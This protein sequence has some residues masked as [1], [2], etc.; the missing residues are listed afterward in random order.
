VP[1]Q[2]QLKR[3]SQRKKKADMDEPCDT[4]AIHV[5]HDARAHHSNHNPKRV[6]KYIKVCVCR[7]SF[8]WRT[9]THIL[10]TSTSNAAQ[11][12][13]IWREKHLSPYLNACKLQR[14]RHTL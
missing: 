14:Y 3:I 2:K 8:G 9:H 7:D 10:L 5:M 13:Y 6:M 11:C 4:T 12:V 1:L